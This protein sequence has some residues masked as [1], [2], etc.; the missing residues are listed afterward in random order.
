MTRVLQFCLLAFVLRFP[1]VQELQLSSAAQRAISAGALTPSKG[2]TSHR[3]V[4]R[5]K[6]FNVRPVSRTV[7]AALLTR[8]EVTPAFG[9]EPTAG[10]RNYFPVST[11]SPA[12]LAR[13]PPFTISN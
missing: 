13:A 1:A 8:R 2:E 9:S 3:I 6:G 5:G 7:G 10:A 11:S 4:A 12:D